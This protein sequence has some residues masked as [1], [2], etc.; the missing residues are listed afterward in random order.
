M[1]LV[2]LQPRVTDC[3]QAIRF[4]RLVPCCNVIVLQAEQH[5]LQTWWSSVKIL[6]LN[7]LQR[8]VIRLFA[9]QV[10]VK[11]FTCVDNRKNFTLDVGV[12]GFCLSKRFTGKMQSD[13]NPA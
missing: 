2:C 1:T 7:H 3:L 13:V 12:P 5:P 4:T 10:R 6:E 8:R 9:I 11:A